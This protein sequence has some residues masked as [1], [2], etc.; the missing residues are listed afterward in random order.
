MREIGFIEVYRRNTVSPKVKRSPAYF[1]LSTLA[2]A[3]ALA[4]CGD[5]PKNDDLGE[6]P[7]TAPE[8]IKLTSP[9]FEKNDTIPTEFTCDGDDVSPPLEWSN[10]PK[11][12]KELALLVTDPDAPSGNF[13]HWTVYEIDPAVRATTVAAVPEGG[14]EG[15]N[16]AGKVGYAGPCPPEGDDAHRYVFALYA[17]DRKLDLAAGASGDEVSS[18]LYRDATARGQ[19]IAKYGR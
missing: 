6:P 12:A 3:I 18:A 8:S 19:L 9:A 17:L 14:K 10:V 4:G 2:C 5:D 15:E 16:S 7:P 1:L 13:V 11:D